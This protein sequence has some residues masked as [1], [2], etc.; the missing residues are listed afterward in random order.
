MCVYAQSVTRSLIQSKSVD[1]FIRKIYVT[2]M[3]EILSR[4][5]SFP[6]ELNLNFK[7][8]RHAA[9]NRYTRDVSAQAQSSE[10]QIDSSR[11]WRR[12]EWR[13]Y[14]IFFISSHVQNYCTLSI[15]SRITRH[16]VHCIIYLHD[17]YFCLRVRSTRDERGY[18]IPIVFTGLSRFSPRTL[19]Y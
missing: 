8:V 5:V 16:P 19:Y 12:Y 13:L 4:A 3:K 1:F 15:G 18:R 11:A 17:I 14:L 7:R 6:R 10:V 9:Q 2:N